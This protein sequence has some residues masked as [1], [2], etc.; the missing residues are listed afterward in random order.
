MIIVGYH[1]TGAYKLYDLN[2]KKIVFNKD[3]KFDETKCWNWKDKASNEFDSHLYLS[4]S[5]T[6]EVETEEQEE[7]VE[8]TNEGG[9]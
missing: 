6:K 5:E 7:I 8:D 4:D 1:L 2:S 9:A 3:V